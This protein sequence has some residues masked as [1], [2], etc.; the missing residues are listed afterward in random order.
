MELKKAFYTVNEVAEILGI[1]A[2]GVRNLI[3]RGVL[4]A[5]KV[6]GGYIILAEDLKKEL[7]AR[8]IKWT[9][10]KKNY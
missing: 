5:E 10:K 9:R 6:N 3:R 7:E 4:K 8:G 1:Y 2:P